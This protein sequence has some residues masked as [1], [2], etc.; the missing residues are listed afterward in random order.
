MTLQTLQDYLCLNR[1]NFQINPKQSFQDASLYFGKARNEEIIADIETGYLAGYMPRVYV[2]GNYGS[3][4]THLLFHLKHHF[5]HSDGALKV[6]PMVVQVEAESKTRYQALHKR[7]ME[8]LGIERVQKA[9]MDYRFKGDDPEG[10]FLELFGQNTYTVMQLLNAGPT[11]APLAWRWLCGERLSV[12]EQQDLGVTAFPTDTGE[13]VDLLVTIGELFKKT[14]QHLLFLV[15]ESE[16]L[17]YVTNADS[18]SSWHEAFRRLAD[19]NDNQSIGWVVT[20]YAT[21]NA[22]A[23]VFMLQGDITTRL[24][25]GGQIVLEPLVSV[26]VKGFLTDLLRAFVDPAKAAALIAEDA[27]PTTADIYPFTEDGL[28]AFVQHAGAAQENAIPRTILRALTACA[29]EALRKKKRLLDKALV[30]MT[31]PNE[32]AELG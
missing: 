25:T 28:A 27:L 21:I 8:A 7:F 10:R 26:E 12:K 31:V 14:D 30:D 15:D 11:M 18:Q 2:F 20:F 1:P 22:E 16:A 6:V 17:H 29:L 13:L 9:Y 19:T 24:G 4:K 32:F 5:E 23:P 3:G